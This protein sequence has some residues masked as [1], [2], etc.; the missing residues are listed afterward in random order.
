MSQIKVSL[1][2]RSSG[3]CLAYANHVVKGDPRKKIRFEA[4]WA[5]IEHPSEGIILF[6]TGYT[7]RFHKATKKFPNSIYA[8][9]TK[10]E[11]ANEQ[12]AKNQISP[13]LVKHIIIS[14][15]HADHVGG[16]LDFPNAIYW[17]SDE[18]LEEFQNLPKWK[19]FSKGL[20]HDLF[21]NDWVNNCRE[22]KSFNTIEHVILGIGYDIFGDNSIV[23]FPLPGHAAG[24]HGALIQTNNGPVFLVADAFW[25]IRAITNNLGPNPIVR[26][27][28]DDWKAYN[29]TLKKL[30][31][32]HESNPEIPLLA[33]HCPNTATLIETKIHS[34]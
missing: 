21:P 22:F 24:Q 25:D 1:S 29:E 14:H 4:T 28:F 26:L 31:I 7:S 15:L 11:V 13:D 16:I 20:L 27:F 12:E 8:K 34:K 5:I 9:L 2:I 6:D 19:G 30:Q 3:H 18:C 32:F 23:M 33:S 17:T 10:V